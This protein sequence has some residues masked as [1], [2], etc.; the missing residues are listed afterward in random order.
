MV[1]IRCGTVQFNNIEA[2][3]FDKDGTL[4]DSNNFLRE[5]S[6]RRTRLL[7]AQ[8]PGIGEPLLMAFGLQNN[9]LD[10]TGL[11]AV[12]SRQENLIAAAAY[13][14]ETGKSWFEALEIAENTF[15]EVDQYLKKDRTTS[16]LFTGSFEVLKI[17]SEAGLKLGILS[18]APTQDV[19]QFVREHNLSNYIQ[20]MMGG[21]QGLTKPDP[22]LFIKACQTLITSPDKTLMVGDAQGDII[23]AKQAGVAGTIGICWA[24]NIAPHLNQ[25]DV[26]ITHIEEIQLS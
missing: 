14:A 8:I 12:G 5:L 20:L 17:L 24:N 3:I 21:D 19:K 1:N 9:Q 4:E 25:A 23:M 10:P 15:S 2:I 26:I 16:P 22:Q 6:I 18:A 13:I 11:M 7:D